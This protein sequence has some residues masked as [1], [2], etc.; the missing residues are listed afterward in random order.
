MESVVDL[1]IVEKLAR[2]GYFYVMHRFGVDNREFVE[3]MISKGLISSISIGVNAESY[4]DIDFF[5]E[6]KILPDYITIDIAHGHCKKMKKMLKYVKEKLPDTFVIAGNV[7]SIE[8]TVDLDKW[9]ADAIKV[10]I[11][12]GCFTPNAETKTTEGVKNLK[13]V[14]I[15]DMILTHKNRFK[16]VTHI[17]KHDNKYEMLKINDLEPSTPKHEYYIINK[18]DKS[19]VNVDNLEHYAYWLEA[20]K[21]DKNKHLLVKL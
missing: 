16:K 4:E 10:G 6:F 19:N 1:D 7:S 8:A 12:P 9:G 17:H 11:G 2:E 13:D 5:S 20:D 18:S 3:S 14:K 21:L 15:G